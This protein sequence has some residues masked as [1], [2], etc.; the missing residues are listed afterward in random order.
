MVIVEVVYVVEKVI[1]YDDNNI[2]QQDVF[3]FNQKG[4]GD[5]NEMMKVLVWQIK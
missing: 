2:I 1:G 3:N 4:I 5:F